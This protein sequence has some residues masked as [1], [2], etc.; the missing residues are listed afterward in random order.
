MKEV[1]CFALCCGCNEPLQFPLATMLLSLHNFWAYYLI[2]VRILSGLPSP[3]N[4]LG[5]K[6]SG[7]S[8]NSLHIIKDNFYSIFLMGKQ[9]FFSPFS[10]ALGYFL[11]PSCYK[12]SH[13]FFP[14]SDYITL[15]QE[16]IE[17]IN[18]CLQMLG[19]FIEFVIPVSFRV[20]GCSHSN[21]SILN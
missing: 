12:C 6:A 2:F 11:V 13:P 5:I 10:L 3:L 20:A 4:F 19:G 18:I 14:C 9:M 1:I 8:V 16:N 7:P 21:P 17:N 15:E